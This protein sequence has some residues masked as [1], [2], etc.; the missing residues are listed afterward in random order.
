M[1]KFAGITGCVFA[2][3]AI[4]LGAFGAHALKD[5]LREADTLNVWQTAV[6]YHMWHALALVV[7][8]LFPKSSRAQAT[9][10]A[11]FIA[12]ILL[13]SGS[14]YWLALEGPRWLGPITPLGGLSFMGG[15]IVLAI[16]FYRCFQKSA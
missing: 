4:A 10:T 14:L 8:A 6:D 3:I 15:W 2:F 5:R 11:L 1:N 7:C 9:A 13:F 16:A 12:G